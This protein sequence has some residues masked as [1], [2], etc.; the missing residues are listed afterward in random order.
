M[1]KSVSEGLKDLI[2][3]ILGFFL[4][5]LVIGTIFQIVIRFL[6]FIF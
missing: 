2:L 5:M 3:S 1:T 4:R 6:A